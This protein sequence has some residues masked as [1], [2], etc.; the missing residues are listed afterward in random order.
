[1]PVK[2]GNRLHPLKTANHNHFQPVIVMQE[3]C[4]RGDARY[5]CTSLHIL[6]MILYPSPSSVHHV[7]LGTRVK[8]FTY[9]HISPVSNVKNPQSKRI[10]QPTPANEANIQLPVLKRIRTPIVLGLAVSCAISSY[11]RRGRHQQ[12]RNETKELHFG[13]AWLFVVL[14]LAL[15]NSVCPRGKKRE[16]KEIT[17]LISERRI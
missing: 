3:M 2:K 8:A 4:M 5:L 16:R 10:K 17:Y 13:L 11:H 7:N 1:M 6:Y 15:K 9:I 12:H 14:N